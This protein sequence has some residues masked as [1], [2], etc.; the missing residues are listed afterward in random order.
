MSEIIT[1]FEYYQNILKNIKKQKTLSINDLIEY[2]CKNQGAREICGLT[3]KILP[4]N[5]PTFTLNE[6]EMKLF[7]KEFI[8]HKNVKEEERMIDAALELEELEMEKIMPEALKAKNAKNELKIINH[9]NKI[10]DSRKMNLTLETL[11]IEKSILNKIEKEIHVSLIKI[12]NEIVDNI[13]YFP[14]FSL[15][16]FNN[17]YMNFLYDRKHNINNYKTLGDFFNNYIGEAAIEAETY[18]WKSVDFN[19]VYYRELENIISKITKDHKKKVIISK[20]IFEEMKKL[21]IKEVF[22]LYNIKENK[23][24]YKEALENA[25]KETEIDEVIDDFVN[26][27]KNIKNKNFL[28]FSDD[29][30]S[31]EPPSEKPFEM[32]EY[33]FLKE[34]K[35][36]DLK[37]FKSNMSNYYCDVHNLNLFIVIEQTNMIDN[38]KKVIKVTSFYIF[39]KTIVEV[40]KENIDISIMP[41]KLT[42][43]YKL[44]VK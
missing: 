33:Q 34:I 2:I 30:E 25:I 14:K 3:D 35:K 28:L 11:N 38:E 40:K 27:I 36:E 1:P 12:I 31:Y 13:V 8:N 10:S 43:K 4:D 22:E 41:N 23:N 42:K 21:K 9:L 20:H 44:I 5:Y 32:S 6:F 24:K 39:D 29:S 19:Y 15:D 26:N 16:Y 7:E 17:K 18:S 37:K